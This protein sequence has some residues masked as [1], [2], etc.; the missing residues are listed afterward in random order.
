M[1]TL[2]QS[3]PWL[4]RVALLAAILA[5]G[6]ACSD[7]NLSVTTKSLP[8]G[9][10]GTNYAAGLSSHSGG[11][12]W[13]LQTGEL[14]PGIGLQDNGNLGGIPTTI[15]TYTFTVGV[16]DFGSGETAYKGLAI[17]VQ[18]DDGTDGT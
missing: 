5:V 14:P 15:G 16:F 17:V 12:V 3:G 10:V 7:C 18:A 4:L 1:T 11:D 9:I 8:D 13:F 2:Q 6:P